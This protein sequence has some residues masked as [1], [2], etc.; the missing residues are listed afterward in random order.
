M[1]NKVVLLSILS[2][3]CLFLSGCGKK[4]VNVNATIELEG[5]P[6]TGYEWTC[7]SSDSNV[8]TLESIYKSNNVDS[9][10]VGA[11]G[12][13]TITLTGVKEGTSTVTCNYKRSWELTESDKEKTYEVSVDKDLQVT[14]K[15]K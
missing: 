9:D 4:E 5:N 3:T 1:K 6:T 10:V 8:V 15:E 13:Y 11:G 2:I 12:T 14:Y 7:V